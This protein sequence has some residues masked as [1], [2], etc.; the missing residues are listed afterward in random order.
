[1]VSSVPRPGVYTLSLANGQPA[2]DGQEIQEG[3]LME[4]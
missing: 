4:A 2:K 3:D 1:M